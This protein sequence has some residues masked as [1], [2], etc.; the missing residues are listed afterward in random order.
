MEKNF[1]IMIYIYILSSLFLYSFFS[2][3][4]TDKNNSTVH[5]DL[6]YQKQLDYKPYPISDVTTTI[7]KTLGMDVDIRC[8]EFPLADNWMHQMGITGVTFSSSFKKNRNAYLLFYYKPS[9]TI[10]TDKFLSSI[11]EISSFNPFQK[12]SF[13]SGIQIIQQLI[14]FNSDDADLVKDGDDDDPGIPYPMPLGGKVTGKLLGNYKTSMNDNRGVVAWKSPIY[15]TVQ[16][17][18]GDDD[19]GIPYPM[20]LGGKIAEMYNL[21]GNPLIVAD[22]DDDDPGIPYPMPLGGKLAPFNYQQIQAIDVRFLEQQVY[23]VAAAFY[24][25]DDDPGIPYPM[26][27]GGKQKNQ[28]VNV[29]YMSTYNVNFNC[30]DNE[31]ALSIA[32]DTKLPSQYNKAILQKAFYKYCLEKDE[33]PG[34]I[35]VTVGNSVNVYCDFLIK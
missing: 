16:M 27:L 12:P 24:D 29:D 32:L 28:N 11:V 19:P 20:P 9:T 10:V 33:T 30:L 14:Q 21:S 22:G 35:K 23:A 2:F 34:S 15:K 25:D 26:P 4:V 18:E 13:S 1:K 3:S 8:P 17:G 31:N 6:I 7:I 5:K